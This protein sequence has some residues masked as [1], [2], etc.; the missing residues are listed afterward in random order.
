M[1]PMVASMPKPKKT[2][3]PGAEVKKL[4]KQPKMFR[5][6]PEDIRKLSEAASKMGVSETVYVQIA[7]RAQFKKDSIT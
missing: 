2:G 7:L 5:L 4:E 3:T 1:H 6:L